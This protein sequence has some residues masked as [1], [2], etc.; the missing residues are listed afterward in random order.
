MIDESDNLQDD[1]KPAGYEIGYGK[2]P[3]KNRFKPGQSGNAR[4]R[5]KGSKS[6][7]AVIRD[8]L[9][10]KVD[11]RTA[12]GS[13]KMPAFEAMIRTNTNQALKGDIKATAQILKMAQL[14]GLVR[15]SDADPDNDPQTLSVE[16]LKILERGIELVTRPPQDME[17]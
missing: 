4:G 6:L 13:R 16:D 11:V 12:R 8:V 5:P 15:E 14:V 7:G 17:P 2:P 3:A 1:A 10:E 9:N